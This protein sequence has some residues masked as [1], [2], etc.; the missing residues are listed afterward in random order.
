M[1]LS[2]GAEARIEKFGNMIVKQRIAKSYR[3]KV[4]DEKIRR[5]RTRSEASM[6]IK[7]RRI[8]IN[9]PKI[10]EISE[11]EIKMEFINGMLIK[12]IIDKNLSHEI[13]VCIEKLHNY[14]IIHGDLTTSN[15][16]LKD[17]KICFIDFGLS[18]SSKRIEDRAVDMHLLKQVIF[19]THE[20]P[21]MLWKEIARGYEDK[22]ILKQIENIE[23]RGRY[24]KKILEI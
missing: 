7:A 6:I 15:M 5:T 17:D 16:I 3:S 22:K 8:G 2:L 9:A 20:N 10:L 1:L 24:A 19:S 11:Y 23:K 14:G 18:F 13:G 4:L 21:D 12:D